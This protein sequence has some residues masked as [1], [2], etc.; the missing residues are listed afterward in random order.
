MFAQVTTATILGSVR[1]DSGAVLPGVSV[2][3]KHLDTGATRVVVTDD[4]G[5]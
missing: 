5:R 1:D 3:V 2:T 4:E